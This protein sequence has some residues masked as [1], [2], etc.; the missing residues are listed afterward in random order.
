MDGFTLIEQLR[1]DPLY[2]QLPVVLLSS[3]HIPNEFEQCQ[4]LQVAAQVT[5]PVK[6]SD[7]LDA[8]ARAVGTHD[9]R[10]DQISRTAADV[11]RQQ[12]AHLK[13]LLAE[14]SVMNQ[15]LVLGLLRNDHDLTVVGDGE[16][17]VDLVSKEHFDVV[18]M[19]VQMPQLD[20]LEATRLIR[21]AERS[22]DRHVPIIAMTAHAMKGDR[23]R[24]LAA[25]MDNYISKPIRAA[26]LY[27]TL[28]DTVGFFRRQR[29]R[30]EKWPG[31]SDRRVGGRLE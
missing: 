29:K 7:L 18:L 10:Q 28:A 6:Q 14:D 30:Y 31:G 15:R 5:K 9:R 2:R 25:G 17:A 8:I 4:R 23:E 26:R 11:P 20:G 1:N 19:D 24:C 21:A 22:T 12:L 13:I 27:E 3:A 16:A